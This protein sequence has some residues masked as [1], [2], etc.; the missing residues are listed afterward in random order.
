MS[1]LNKQKITHIMLFYA[2]K[3][4]YNA[5]H[6]KLQNMNVL[7]QLTKYVILKNGQN[8]TNNTCFS[9]KHTNT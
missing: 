1:K 7:P 3:S 6:W 9:L 2:N 8:Y 4:L 5:K